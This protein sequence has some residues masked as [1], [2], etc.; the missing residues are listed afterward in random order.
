FLIFGIAWIWLSNQALELFALDEP[1]DQRLKFAKAV[2]FAVLSALL[3]Y[4]LVRRAEKRQAALQAEA[5][6]ERDRLAQILNVT[7]AVIYSLKPQTPGGSK[8]VVDFVSQNVQTFTGYPV[9]VL[10]RD[11]EFWWELTH[12]DDRE[13]VDAMRKELQEAGSLKHEYRIR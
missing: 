2:A 6:R 5:D 9:E 11:V 13:R 12:P 8:M 1:L 10:T 4:T 7:P 3:I